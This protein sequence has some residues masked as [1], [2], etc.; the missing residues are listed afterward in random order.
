[1]MHIHVPQEKWDK[2]EKS[3]KKDKIREKQPNEQ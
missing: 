3:L 1:M 2:F